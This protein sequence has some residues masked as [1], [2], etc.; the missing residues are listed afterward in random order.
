MVDLDE[1]LTSTYSQRIRNGDSQWQAVLVNGRRLRSDEI[2]S[3]LVL[4]KAVP[5]RHVDPIDGRD[6]RYAYC[7]VSAAICSIL[8]AISGPVVNRPVPMSLTGTPRTSAQ[9]L[10]LARN[11]GVSIGGPDRSRGEFVEIAVIGGRVLSR[12]KVEPGIREAARSVSNMVPELAISTFWEVRGSSWAFC[13][14]SNV[15]DY[16]ALGDASAD[17]LVE[18]MSSKS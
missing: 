17:A 9:W 12:S 8:A 18:I 10:A 13:G 11:A 14:G 1:L 3:C 15:V 7:E 2:A 4:P 16:A 5:A 6:R